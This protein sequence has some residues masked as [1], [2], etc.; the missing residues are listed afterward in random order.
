[1]SVVGC[2]DSPERSNPLDPKSESFDNSGVVTG[3]VLSYYTPFSPIPDA[4]VRFDPGGFL[5]LSN[6]QGEF[7]LPD[8][9]ADTY[10][11][12]ATKEGYADAT[13]SV[14]VILGQ[15]TQMQLN[16]NGLPIFESI[17]V[18]SGH[19][20]RTFPANDLF[21]LQAE[22]ETDD[23]DGFNDIEFVEIEIPQ[24]GFV[25]TLSVTQT[26]GVFSGRILES[27]INANSLS[28]ILGHPIFLIAH[29]RPGASHRSDARF[30]ARIIDRTP[31][32]ESP[33]ERELLTD[34]TPTLVWRAVD[35]PYAFTYRVEVLSV[36]FGVVTPVWS[37]SGIESTQTSVE[38]TESLISGD[39]NWAVA[40][41]DEFGNWSR[42]QEASFR[43][44]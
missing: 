40:I 6:T 22:T 41:V 32:T 5:A 11:V 21:F 24:F 27:E 43:I 18:T 29:D 8:I 31:Q 10:T 17:L 1:M 37:L 28:N 42:S 25:D 23:P 33:D 35:L 12:R 20:S 34:P 4:E 44:N 36:D 39:Y 2:L 15:P 30:V 13:V 3:R 14:D 19:V 9:P 38:V 7:S 16:L 26:P